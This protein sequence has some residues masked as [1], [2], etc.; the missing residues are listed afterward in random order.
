MCLKT[1]GNISNFQLEEKVNVHDVRFEK[2]SIFFN[3]FSG[4]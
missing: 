2:Q 4:I 1:H 3:L